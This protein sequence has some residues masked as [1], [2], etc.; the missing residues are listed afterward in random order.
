MKL[1]TVKKYAL[2]IASALV[3]ITGGIAIAELTSKED[4][5]AVMAC[6]T[7]LKA[8]LKS[9]KS[10][11][12]VEAKISG[13][14]VIIA[15]DAVNSFNAPIRDEKVC[16]FELNND[17]NFALA[18]PHPSADIKALTDEINGLDKSNL[19]PEVAQ[20]YRDRIADLTKKGMEDVLASAQDERSLSGNNWYPI[21]PAKTKLASGA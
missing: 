6:E 20:N 21:D 3:A 2:W 14:V 9:P 1:G 10:Y 11:E 17:G 18:A 12:R 8:K 4:D 16:N 15:Y 7:V 19:T 13:S 5:P